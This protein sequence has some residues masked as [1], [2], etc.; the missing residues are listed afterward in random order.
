MIALQKEDGTLEAVYCHYDGYPEGV[1]KTLKE[2]Y[3]DPDKVERLIEGG[4]M[5]CLAP[6]VEDCEYYTGWGEKLKIYTAPNTSA[7]AK[8]SKEL[9]CEYLY[10]YDPSQDTENKWLITDLHN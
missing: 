8:E 3:Q 9:W 10:V 5:S 1:G 4:G 2:H 7:L 6:D